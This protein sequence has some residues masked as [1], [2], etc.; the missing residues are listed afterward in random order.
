MQKFL[1]KIDWVLLFRMLM[2]V[3]MIIVGYQSSDNLPMVF[4]GFFAVY[5]LIASKYKV[6]CGYQ[7]SCGIPNQFEFKSGKNTTKEEVEFKEVK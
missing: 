2:S 3:S 7:G 1:A 5:S 6:G 4:G